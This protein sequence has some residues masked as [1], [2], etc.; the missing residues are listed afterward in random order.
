MRTIFTFLALLTWVALFAQEKGVTPLSTPPPGGEGQGE[1][2]AVV[3]GISDYQDHAIPDLRFA[4][5][6]A[7]A[8][9][10]FLRSP[11]G[12]ALDDDHLRVLTN[13]QATAGRIAEAL[14]GLIEQVK[15]GDQ[16]IIYFSGH[17]DVEGKKIS[18]PGFLLCWDS[19]S[20]VYM[21]GGTYSL[22][23]LQEV[24]STL[25]MQN[26]ARVTVITDACHAGKLAG[27]Q[28]GGAQLTSANLAKQY[29]N[30]IKI[31]SCQPNE[32]SLEG[33]QWGGGRGAFSY[34]LVEGLV[35]L[36]DRNN[37]GA[38]T[39]GEID[40]YLEDHVTAEAAP[41]SQVPMLLGNKTD[42]LSTVNA[43]VLADLRKNKSG[44]L[45][46]FAATE[47]RG[48]EEEVLAKVDS[49]VRKQY[50]AFKLAVQEKRFFEPAGNCADDL[51][52]Q[53]SG[54]ESLA[55]LGGIM[56]RNYAAAL[57]DDAQQTI[58]GWLKPDK[59]ISLQAAVSGRMP[60]KVFTEKVKTYPRCLERAAELLG[61]KHYMYADLIARKYF[62]EGYLL[63]NSNRNPD[64]ELGER[65]LTLFRKS[66]NYQPEQPHV[67]WQMLLVF[68]YN[69]LQPDSV[70][71]YSRRALELYPN[72]TVPCTEAAYLLSYKY[73]QQERA[74]WFLEQAT[75][76]DSSS[77]E[78]WHKWAIFNFGQKNFE[79]AEW[80]LKK[81][82]ALDATNATIWN[83]LGYMYNLTGRYEEAEAMFK[84]AIAMDSTDIAAWS[85]LG[86]L[87]DDTNRFKEAEHAFKKA[88]SLDATFAAT[89][90]LLGYFYF[91]TNRFNEAEQALKKV[92]ELDS[93]QHYAWDNLGKVYQA[94]GR[95]AEAE[96]HFK[97]AI[98]IDSTFMAHWNNL[99]WLYN[100]TRRFAEAEPIFKKVI[101]F[102]ST[103]FAPWVGLGMNY[104]QTRRYGEA[105]T[106]FKKVISIDSTQSMVWN[107]LGFIYL[108]IQRYTEAIPVLKKA[109][110]LDSM[111]ANPRR[112]LGMAYFKINHPEEARQNFLKAIVL[113][114]DYAN[115]MLGMAYLLFS[116]GKTA[117]ALGYVEQAIGK[118]STFEQLEADQD[119][120]PLRVTLEWKVLM[121]KYFPDR[122]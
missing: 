112:H 100:N 77:V 34:H 69:F 78:V 48:L 102:D 65:T 44:G 72:W 117:E 19:P 104:I 22:S 113:N 92:I 38:V 27:S 84:K 96:Y 17:G 47:S 13:G 53:L 10:N 70:E 42:R 26:K 35:G 45:P 82:I 18:Q 62:F 56:K 58:N 95:Y 88:I 40:R 15:E 86:G 20:R 2:Y 73:N 79:E 24:I 51:Y 118:G 57:Q 43:A 3:V 5:K 67:Y 29:A 61:E 64:Q 11:A 99:G 8:F 110:S 7:L 122:P 52:T 33:E 31:L 107:N 30:E 115:A 75:R 23:F 4:D 83:N 28:I 59:E 71:Y 63:A 116:E 16:V 119:L 76:I 36:A 105:E 74:R 66:L 109:I 108:Q 39:V 9:A 1:V 21:G 93:T 55:P 111:F 91:H 94:I 60:Q 81:A 12:G 89:W 120:A 80:Q 97:K 90:N 46:V 32:F 101:V 25:S 14:D 41:Q 87:F 121:K 50:L 49:T 103:N 98:S 37:D 106:A 68:G 114:P 6:D 54:V 85:N